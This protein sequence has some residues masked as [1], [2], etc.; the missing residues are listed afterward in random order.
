MMRCRDCWYLLS[1]F[2][3]C[4]RV[5]VYFLH[6]FCWNWRKLFLSQLNAQMSFILAVC[7]GRT[8]ALMSGNG[9]KRAS[10]REPLFF[11]SDSVAVKFSAWIF[12]Q[13]GFP[14]RNFFRLLSLHN[15]HNFLSLQEKSQEIIFVEIF[16]RLNRQ[17]KQVV[18]SVCEC[19]WLKWVDLHCLL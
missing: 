10:W 3:L 13:N 12:N 19:S 16:G 11:Q 17:V 6:F 7:R 18:E 8:S 5:H 14:V 15:K 9:K 4:L 1:H 2:T